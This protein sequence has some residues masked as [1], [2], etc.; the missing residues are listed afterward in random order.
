MLEAT[1]SEHKNKLIKLKDDGGLSKNVDSA[2][3]LVF[4]LRLYG[5]QASSTEQKKG[6]ITQLIKGDALLITKGGAP[7]LLIDLLSVPSQ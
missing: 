2:I 4:S 1:I 6:Y 3:D 5:L 7:A